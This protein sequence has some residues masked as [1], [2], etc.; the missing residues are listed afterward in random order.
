MAT[1]ENEG[2]GRGSTT[3]RLSSS[4][5][6]RGCVVDEVAGRG[7]IRTTKIDEVVLVGGG[8]PDEAE[9]QESSTRRIDSTSSSPYPASSARIPWRGTAADELAAL[10]SVLSSSQSSGSLKSSVS[11]SP[12]SEEGVVVE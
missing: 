11:S 3:T 9:C 12:T 8:D 2:R 7:G 1:G 4:G 6:R 5:E 10:A